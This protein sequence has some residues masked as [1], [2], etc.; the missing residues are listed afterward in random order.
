MQTCSRAA[1][2]EGYISFAASGTSAYS[3]ETIQVNK[4]PPQTPNAQFNTVFALGYMR[5]TL[6]TKNFATL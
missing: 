5:M 4:W 6:K 2:I 1:Y 3:R